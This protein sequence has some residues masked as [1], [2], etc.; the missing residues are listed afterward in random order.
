M[1]H[2]GFWACQ[3]ERGRPDAPP[4][5]RFEYTFTSHEAAFDLNGIGRE[6]IA[7]DIGQPV[8]HD[9]LG[10]GVD[11]DSGQIDIRKATCGNYPGFKHKDRIV[12][13]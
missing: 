5:T 11:A 3:P 13:Y 6:K 8:G 4:S 12:S 9:A 7:P 10:I 2:S 1:I